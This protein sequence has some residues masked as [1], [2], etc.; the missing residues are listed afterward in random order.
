MY[1]FGREVCDQGLY[2]AEVSVQYSG[3]HITTQGRSPVLCRKVDL[4]VGRVLWVTDRPVRRGRLLKPVKIKHL[5]MFRCDRAL[6][7]LVGV[8]TNEAD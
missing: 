3:K 1:Q 6:C 2:I 4:K 8:S 7:M 5:A